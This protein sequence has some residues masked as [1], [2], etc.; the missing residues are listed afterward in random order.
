MRVKASNASALGEILLERRTGGGMQREKAAFLELRGP[1]E[2][3]IGSHILH[4]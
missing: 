2:Q 1:N 4:M 3:P